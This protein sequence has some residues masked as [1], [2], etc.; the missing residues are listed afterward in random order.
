[1]KKGKAKVDEI[2][3]A[4]FDIN[5]LGNQQADCRSSSHNKSYLSEICTVTITENVQIWDN[6]PKDVKPRNVAYVLL[7]SNDN[8]TRV[9]LIK[10]IKSGDIADKAFWQTACH[11][12]E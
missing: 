1:M 12:I 7:L 5:Y 9:A 6:F 4:K 3:Q 8:T 11:I 2:K 10:P